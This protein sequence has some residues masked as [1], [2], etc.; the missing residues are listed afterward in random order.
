MVSTGSPRSYYTG[1]LSMGHHVRRML[2]AALDAFARM[3]SRAALAVAHEDQD[4]D[5]DMEAVMRQLITYMME[6]P[7][8]IR[9]VL[10]AVLAVRAFERIGDHADNICENAIFMV[11]GK[12]VRHVALEE[13]E[14]EL[15]RSRE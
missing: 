5:Q 12:D 3:D 10:D 11:E 13:I 4:V 8:S 1:V 7:R 6:D 2:R 15:N 14:Q 9:G